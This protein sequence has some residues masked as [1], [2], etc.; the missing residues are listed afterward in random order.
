MI[1]TILII[2]L[3]I[4]VAAFLTMLALFG[5]LTGGRGA[6][7]RKAQAEE[8][9]M[10]QEMYRDLSELVQRIDSLETILL[11]REHRAEEAAG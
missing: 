6:A 7:A 8:A 9:K 4:G 10:I 3:T 2:L 5:V 11:D 1:V